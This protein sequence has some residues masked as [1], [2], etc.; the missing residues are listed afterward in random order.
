MKKKNYK[1]ILSKIKRLLTW[2]KHRNLTLM[3]KIQFIKGTYFFLKMIYV[4]SITAV[5]RWVYDSLDELVY[6]F[7]WRGKHKIKKRLCFWI[8]REGD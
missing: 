2:L 1:D 6:D 5:P 7:I 8:I 4:A 3:G